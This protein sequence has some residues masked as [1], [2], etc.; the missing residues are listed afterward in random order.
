MSEHRK[1]GS[2][3]HLAM[4]LYLRSSVHEML[5]ENMYLWQTMV[6]SCL[7]LAALP[8]DQGTVSHCTRAGPKSADRTFGVCSGVSGKQ[9]WIAPWQI[10]ALPVIG[11][12]RLSHAPDPKDEDLLE[13]PCVK[14]LIFRPLGLPVRWDRPAHLVCL[15]ST[16]PKG[17]SS[18]CGFQII[19]LQYLMAPRCFCE[20]LLMSAILHSFFFFPL[21]NTWD[22]C[23]CLRAVSGAVYSHRTLVVTCTTGFKVNR[24][25]KQRDLKSST[26]QSTAAQIVNCCWSLQSAT[27]KKSSKEK[28]CRKKATR[29]V[30]GD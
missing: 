23:I 30:R 25:L 28:R 6:W 2:G 7:I 1:Y 12:K 29:I 10:S 21:S 16:L 18:G 15:W 14:S 5:S 19:F 8:L 13:L 17:C 9:V 3:E 11:L 26:P 4:V 20:D 22:G 24:Q 27:S